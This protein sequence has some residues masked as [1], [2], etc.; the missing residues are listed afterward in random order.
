[1]YICSSIANVFS[2]IRIKYH[3]GDY[4]KVGSMADIDPLVIE[5][6]ENGLQKETFEK[7]VREGSRNEKI[8]AFFEELFKNSQLVFY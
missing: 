1:M 3:F 6:I 7:V 5:D 8:L 2:S 4:R